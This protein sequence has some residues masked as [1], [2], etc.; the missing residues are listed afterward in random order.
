MYLTNQ[1]TLSG[2]AEA[3]KYVAASKWSCAHVV[4]DSVTGVNTAQQLLACAKVLQSGQPLWLPLTFEAGSTKAAGNL[5]LLPFTA[6]C[7]QLHH[8]FCSESISIIVVTA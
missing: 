7:S 6:V 3:W 8:I 1:E 5:T 2:S 4:Y